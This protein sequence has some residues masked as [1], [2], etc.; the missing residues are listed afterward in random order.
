MCVAFLAVNDKDIINT[1]LI[2]LTQCQKSIY[3]YQNR[4]YELVGITQQY[5]TVDTMAKD[6]HR[7]V[8]WI[9]ELL[10]SAMVDVSE[11]D[12]MHQAQ[13]FEFQKYTGT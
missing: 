9:E 10:C 13:D 4:I 11:V 6:I 5:R 2:R 7:V 12:R 3:K 8:N 1:Q